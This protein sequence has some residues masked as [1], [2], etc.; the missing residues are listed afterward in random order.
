MI[1]RV[2]LL[3]FTVT[4][5]NC[6]SA[7]GRTSRGPVISFVGLPLT[8]RGGD[9]ESWGYSPCVTERLAGSTRYRLSTCLSCWSVWLSR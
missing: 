7:P 2:G 3:W 9:T 6:P 5:S 4:T 1:E 8:S